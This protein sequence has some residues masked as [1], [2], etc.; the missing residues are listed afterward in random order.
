MK[1]SQD[2]QDSWDLED[3]KVPQASLAQR[4]PRAPLDFQGHLDHLGTEG[5]Q[6]RSLGPSLGPGE[7][8]DFRDSLG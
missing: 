4:G 5:F 3:P 8:L 6:E 1:A 2:P 7:M